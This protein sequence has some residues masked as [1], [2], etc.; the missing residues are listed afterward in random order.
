MSL[1]WWGRGL[2]RRIGDREGFEENGFDEQFARGIGMKSVV[3]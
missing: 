2:I 1:C 3:I